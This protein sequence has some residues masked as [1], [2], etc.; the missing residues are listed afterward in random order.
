MSTPSVWDTARVAADLILEMPGGVPLFFRRIAAGGESFITG[1]RDDY[2]GEEPVHR[3]AFPEGHDFFIGTFVVTQEQWSAVAERSRKLRERI[4]PSAFKGP[5]RPVENVSWDDAV[6]WCEALMELPEWSSTVHGLVARLPTVAEWEYACR[7]RSGTDYHNGDGEAAL[8]EVGWYSRNSGFETHPVDESVGGRTEVHPYGLF[9]MHGNV[10][11]WCWDAYYRYS[12]RRRVDGV[13]AF[14]TGWR[15][16]AED[17]AR[18]R[19]FR[20]GSWG[21]PPAY[22]RSAFRFRGHPRYRNGILGVRVCL[23]PG[24]AEI[25]AETGQRMAEPE[26]GDGGRGTRPESDGWGGAGAAEIDLKSESF[27]GEAGRK[28]SQ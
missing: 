13:V 8:A 7:G 12:Y 27:A 14:E 16:G 28:K 1:A 18:P 21:D 11:E 3:V 15:V 23:A 17:G 10:Y 24:P 26:P 2:R 22:C 6:A 5:R 19:V 20:G 25:Q 4:D 9:G